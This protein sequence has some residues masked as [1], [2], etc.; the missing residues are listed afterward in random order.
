MKILFVK[1]A[2]KELL[3]LDKNLGKRILNKI[4]LL[5]NDPYGNSQKLKG[6]KGYRIRI[7]DYRVVYTIDKKKQTILIIKIGHRRDIYR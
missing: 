5:K 2:E 7:G 4:S 3:H 6:N 1:S